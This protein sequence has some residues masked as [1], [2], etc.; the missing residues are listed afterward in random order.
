MNIS[1]SVF[2]MSIQRDNKIC[3]YRMMGNV[4]LKPATIT[5]HYKVSYLMFHIHDIGTYVFSV[6][7]V[8]INIT[9]LTYKISQD[10]GP[11]KYGIL[12]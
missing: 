11:I 8:C 6:I 2:C 10:R 9:L 5:Y 4:F 12:L 3:D 7:S 1:L